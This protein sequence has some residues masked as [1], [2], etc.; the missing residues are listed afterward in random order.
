[1]R[2]AHKVW[3]GIAAGVFGLV[4]VTDLAG[5]SVPPAG[6]V[7]SSSTLP[8]SSG[9]ASPGAMPAVAPAVAGPA[10]MS[11][12]VID[13]IDGDTFRL[14]SGDEVRV[15]GIDSCEAATPGGR[16]AT[17]AARTRLLSA[18][19]TLTAE[20]GVD[21]DRYGRMLRYVGAGGADFASSMVTQDHTAIYTR[22]RNDA[23]TAVRSTLRR[24]D[25]D[26]R[27]CGTA[28]STAPTTPRT[29]TATR[30]PDADVDRPRT[31]RPV[32]PRT[33]PRAAAGSSG[34]SSGG[35]GYYANCSA[36][37]AAGAAPLRA[38]APGYRAA[39]DRDK[40]GVACE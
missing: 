30:T 11:A 31:P 7:A 37:R 39:L 21:R 2:T 25:T 18:P 24:L 36:A 28:L 5:S 12:S 20:P 22:G 19:V 4:A 34:G 17:A 15:L 29:T 38:G 35:G 14:A 3:S 16:R 27:S 9:A 32:A 33:A 10:A 13:V 1:M 6:T 26:G 23:S 8:A 40:D